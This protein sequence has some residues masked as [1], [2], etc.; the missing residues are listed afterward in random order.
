M[1]RITPADGASAAQLLKSMASLAESGDCGNILSDDETAEIDRLV[2]LLD[3]P[4]VYR[5]NIVAD[6][7]TAMAESVPENEWA[8]AWQADLLF[9]AQ[10]LRE[11]ATTVV[12]PV[13]E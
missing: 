7:L 5:E 2:A 8:G 12:P 9:A 10:R 11:N 3:P 4:L 13:D 1:P 6:K